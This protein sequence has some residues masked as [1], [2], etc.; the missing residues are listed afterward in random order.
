MTSR[1]RR[2][3]A[4]GGSA[5]V[6]ALALAGPAFA[7]FPAT[8]GRIVFVSFRS[9]APTLFTVDPT[10]PTTSLATLTSA[11]DDQD[12]AVSPDGTTVAF[13]RTAN[14]TPGIYTV[15]LAATSQESAVHL[16]VA[17]PTAIEPS[18]SPDG[19]TLIYVS[20][21]NGV[22]TLE[23]IDTTA[24]SP[25]PTVLFTD[26]AN[27]DDPVFDPADPT[28]IVFVR[29]TSPGV[30]QISLY[31]TTTHAAPINLSNVAANDS[32]PDFSSNGQWIVF[33]SDRGVTSQLWSMSVTGANQH[34][35][36][37]TPTG[38]ADTDPAFSP[39]GSFVTW[40]RP[41][42]SASKEIETLSTALTYTASGPTVGPSASVTDDS[43]SSATDVEPVWAPLTQAGVNLPEV[44][45]PALLGVAGIASFAAVA[46]FR[47]RRSA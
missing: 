29:S 2:A 15:P 3:V 18:W 25:T 26:T 47:R 11:G 1:R 36:F 16:V 40:V 41:M 7:A 22:R 38:V 9:G 45:A 28:K 6:L 37:S 33:Q 42:V 4:T 20:T 46:L 35:L 24:A 39:D 27:D 43:L 19:H 44:G 10:A 5:V 34:A 23:T 14:V 17:D 8:N 12:P 31:S 32:T 30:S 13:S 21:V